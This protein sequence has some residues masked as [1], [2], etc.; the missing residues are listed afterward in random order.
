VPSVSDHPLISDQHFVSRIFPASNI[1][2]RRPNCALGR[3]SPSVRIAHR[4]GGLRG[5]VYTNGASH[6]G[7]YADLREHRLCQF[8]LVCRTCPR[9]GRQLLEH[10][11]AR[12]R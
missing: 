9:A 4:I 3:K 7:S 2:A 11:R 12:G 6:G 10:R 5:T 8:Q 1:Q